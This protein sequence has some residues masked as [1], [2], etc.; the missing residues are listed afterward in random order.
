M[1]KGYR[2]RVQKDPN[3]PLPEARRLPVIEASMGDFPNDPTSIDPEFSPHEGEPDPDLDPEGN[4]AY[5][6]VHDLREEVEKAKARDRKNKKTSMLHWGA[7]EGFESPQI[8]TV[9][10]DSLDGDYTQRDVPKF[11]VHCRTCNY[12]S[13]PMAYD[14]GIEHKREH[15]QSRGEPLPYG[16]KSRSE[17]MAPKPAYPSDYAGEMGDTRDYETSQLEADQMLRHLPHKMNMLHWSGVQDSGISEDVDP[18]TADAMDEASSVQKAY[19]DQA[20]AAQDDWYFN[21]PNNTKPFSDNSANVPTYMA[22]LPHGAAKGWGTKFKYRRSGNMTYE[23]HDPDT[24]EHHGTVWKTRFGWSAKT[25]EG[26]QVVE[27]YPVSRDLAAWNLARHPKTSMVRW[28]AEAAEETLHDEPEG[29]APYGGGAPSEDWQA[30]HPL[31][32]PIPSGRSWG[33]GSPS[34]PGYVHEDLAALRPTRRG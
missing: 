31:R 5:W 21:Q 28:G 16:P 27:D 10:L 23:V 3:T 11:Q 19:N 29:H 2:R 34:D 24:D 9:Q 17:P 6:A 7:A 30:Q 20:E 26:E 32:P 4:E 1:I 14:Q 18:G 13:I 12:K 15:E 33:S 25:P 8:H 22:A